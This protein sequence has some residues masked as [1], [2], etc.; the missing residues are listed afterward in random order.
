MSSAENRIDLEP[1]QTSLI[2]GRRFDRLAVL[3]EPSGSFKNRV[4]MSFEHRPSVDADD[5]AAQTAARALQ[6]ASRQIETLFE[7]CTS[8][9]NA[10]DLPGFLQCYDTSARTSYLSGAQIVVGYEAIENLYATRLGARGPAAM[11]NLRM[12]LLRV[13]LL[14]RDHAHAIGRFV[15]TRE[16]ALGG[17]EQGIFSVVLQQSSLG[18]RIVADHTSS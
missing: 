10:G 6:A 4:V 5:E 8:A 17:A 11:G 3:R 2:G 13:A 1:G 18:W 15:L 7:H 12:S 14:G 9:W 16:E